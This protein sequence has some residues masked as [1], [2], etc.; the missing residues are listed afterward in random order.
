MHPQGQC[1]PTHSTINK[2]SPL[3]CHSKWW[4]M[5]IRSKGHYIL[6]E[7]QALRCCNIHNEDVGGGQFNWEQHINGK[8]HLKKLEKA[9]LPPINHKQQIVSFF[10]PKSTQQ[11][12]VL[13]MP[14]PINATSSSQKLLDAIIIDDV[15]EDIE[16]TPI[17]AL[18]HPLLRWLQDQ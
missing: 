14:P 12:V 16:G 6:N 11:S 1:C 8:E 7:I 10:T 17:K 2:D 13:N 3:Y 4:V 18:P 5:Q 9:N 15:I